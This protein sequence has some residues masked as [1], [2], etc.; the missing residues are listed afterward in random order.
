MCSY[1]R[2][3]ISSPSYHWWWSGFHGDTRYS[4]SGA[5]VHV[6]TSN[7]LAQTGSREGDCGGGS[8]VGGKCAS[9]PGT[10]ICFWTELSLLPPSQACCQTQCARS[11]PFCKGPCLQFWNTR[12]TKSGFTLGLKLF[13][14]HSLTQG[15]LYSVLLLFRKPQSVS[16]VKWWGS[17]ASTNDSQQT[18]EQFC[19]SK[20][21]LPFKTWQA[22]K[23]H[24][25]MHL[26]CWVFSRGSGSA[27][28]LFWLPAT[29]LPTTG[30]PWQ[31]VT[32]GLCIGLTWQGFVSS[33]AT[34]V[35]SVSRAPCHIRASPSCSKRDPLLPELRY[36]Q[37]WVCSG[38]D[39]RKG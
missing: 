21:P 25:P 23:L 33:G 24:I 32:V 1:F 2:V 16:P 11:R 22:F 15:Q 3:Y 30:S 39:L 5:W 20:D 9:F 34:G 8:V 10:E 19:L 12:R 7:V 18:V 36:K 17:T 38:R 35:T 26:V 27:E 31:L 13:L 29:S 14:F 6:P 28:T 37:Q 4:W